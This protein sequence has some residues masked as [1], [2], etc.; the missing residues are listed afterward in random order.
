MA[1]IYISPSTQDWNRYAGGGNEETYL[2]AICIP[3]AAK[4]AAAGHVVRVGGVKSAA[5]NAADANAWGC[6]WYVAGHS[7]AGGGVG[8]EAWYFTGSKQG[9]RLADAI[10]ARVAAVSSAPD[11]GVKHSTGYIELRAPHA[12]A[13]IIEIDFHD[14]LANAAEIRANTP[15]YAA[16]TARGVLDVAGGG[17]VVPAPTTPPSTPAPKPPKVPV[18]VVKA[19]KLHLRAGIMKRVLH[20]VSRGDVLTVLGSRLGWYKV[21]HGSI[22]GWVSGAFVRKG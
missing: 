16:A 5:D 18:V 15:E 11:R 13:C 19:A 1:R 6:D 4:I 21:R 10:Y 22:V 2:R 14:R 8:T 12:P 17:M 20:T 3:A 7:N 9:K